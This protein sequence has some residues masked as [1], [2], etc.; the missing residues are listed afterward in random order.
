[1]MMSKMNWTLSAILGLASLVAVAPQASAQP[2]NLGTFKL[3]VAAQFGDRVLQPGEY[4]VTR[5]EGMSAIRVRGEGG[6]ATVMAN[7][8]DSEPTFDRS[9][10]TLAS[11]NG[12]FALTRFDSG[13]L[14][15]RYD[16]VPNKKAL[17][18]NSER[19]SIGHQSDL[20]IGLK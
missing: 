9:K 16:F 18:R 11:I 20:E 5:V 13:A 8:V 12:T 17:S 2:T 3:P 14:G 19:A 15:R 10:M 1:M 4:T 6:T 7:S